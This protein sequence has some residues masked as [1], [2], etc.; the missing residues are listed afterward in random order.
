[1]PSAQGYLGY[2]VEALR[3]RELFQWIELSPIT[4]WQALLYRDPYN[5]GGVE[6]GPDPVEGQDGGEGEGGGGGGGPTI[7]YYWSMKDYLPVA[8]Q[9]P[10]ALLLTEFIYLPWREGQKAQAQAQTQ[11]HGGEMV[12]EASIL[13]HQDPKASTTTAAAAHHD[14]AS[15]LLHQ[16]M[17]R[18][19]ERMLKLVQEVTRQAHHAPLAMRKEYAFPKMA[20]SHLTEEELGSPALA[21]VK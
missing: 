3:R 6:A 15:Y 19:T 18:V 17:P 9:E 21:F 16:L 13:H 11:G 8:L 2:L 20:G 7:R 10:L 5:Y 1:M 14:D 12:D 4:W